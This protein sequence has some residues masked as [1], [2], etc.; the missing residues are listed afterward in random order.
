MQTA[1]PSPVDHFRI[2][3]LVRYTLLGLLLAL[4]LPLPVLATRQNAPV[5][6]TVL[7]ALIVFAWMLLVAALSQRVETD[8]EGVRVDYPAWVPAFFGKRWRVRWADIV[9]LK[10]SRTS[11][12]G[13]VHYL[14]D[15]RGDRYLLPMRIAGFARFLRIFQA[16]TGID[17]AA[18]STLAQPW[19][20]LALLACV[21][22]L[23]GCDLLVVA[24]ALGSR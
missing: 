18:V 22:V 11:Q 8:T 17:T 19:M 9:A 7:V 1:P 14:V 20:Y 12:G 2:S 5:S 21:V 4:M 10:A 23:F 16:Q 15:R 6:P 24:A 3:P 13:Q